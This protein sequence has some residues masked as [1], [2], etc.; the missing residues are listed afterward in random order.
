MSASKNGLCGLKNKCLSETTW[1]FVVLWLALLAFGQQYINDLSEIPRAFQA[2]RGAH[3]LPPAVQEMATL[4]K[5]RKLT[6]YALSK[7]IADD[8]HVYQR[9]IEHLYP[10]RLSEQAHAMFAI[11]GETP[12]THCALLEPGTTVS[13]YECRR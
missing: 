5:A 12:P 2:E 9:A 1:S 13:L 7:A 3:A 11:Q 6:A 4:V 8:F 10:A